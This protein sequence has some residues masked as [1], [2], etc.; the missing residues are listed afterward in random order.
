MT[1][2]DV[3]AEQ[4]VI[5]SILVDSACLPAVEAEL[6]ADDFAMEINREIYRAALT[7][8][9]RSEPVDPVT[10]LEE[11]TRSGV[12]VQRDY[13]L[14]LMDITPTAANAGEYAK[15]THRNAMRRAAGLLGQEMVDAAGRHEDPEQ[16]L[17]QAAQRL[18]ELQNGGI[19]S[20]LHTSSESILA[21]YEH[22]A[23][24]EEGKTPG[25]VSTGYRDI[26]TALGGGLLCG[27][28][29]IL[30]ARPG[31]GKSTLALN[32][33]ERVAERGGAVLFVSLEMSEREVTAKRLARVCGIPS[34]RLLMGRI[35]EAEGRRLAEASARLSRAPMVTSDKPVVTVDDVV[36]MAR[37]VRGVCLV[38]VD[39]MGKLDPGDRKNVGRTEYMTEI[40][41]ALKNMARMLRIPA[42]VLAQL[43]R[44]SEDR[45]D[46]RPQLSDLRDTG[47]IEQDAD[48]VIFLYREDYYQ[49]KDR[50]EDPFAPS[51][52][53]VI[54]EKNR[55]GPTGRCEMAF[56]KALSKISTVNNDP[57]RALRAEMK[58][59]IS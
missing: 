58:A 51:P 5:G 27:G 4:S 15:I 16:I 12:Q 20:D 43:N 37:K 6:R 26:D 28:L 49:G 53:E 42:L 10:V 46:R 44:K 24:V 41:G 48:T 52:L 29:H 36:S 19:R 39:Y 9:H 35:D 34:T 50:S 54:V 23:A 32:I 7:L 11:L 40:S 55:H 56:C 45:S 33:A 18:H 22:R 3:Q 1:K 13:L 2:N 14:E 31:M 57:R 21:F 59:G 38:V 25:F 30:A 8:S 17:G 47:A